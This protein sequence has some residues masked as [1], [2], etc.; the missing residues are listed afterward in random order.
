MVGKLQPEGITYDTTNLYQIDA[1]RS[2]QKFSQE[3]IQGGKAP[4]LRASWKGKNLSL[5]ASIMP[6]F[7]GH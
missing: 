7:V 5:E 6:K 3:L 1:C 4:L 2:G